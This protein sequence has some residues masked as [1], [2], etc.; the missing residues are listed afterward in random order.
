MKTVD[1]YA[2]VVVHFHDI[3][4]AKLRAAFHFFRSDITNRSSGVTYAV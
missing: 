4:P 1:P 2:A 3:F